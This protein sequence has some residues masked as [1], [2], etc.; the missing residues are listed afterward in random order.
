[1]EE[2]EQTGLQTDESASE[3]SPDATSPIGRLSRTQVV[4]ILGAAMMSL[5]LAA[6]DQTIVATALPRIVADVGGIDQISWVVTSYLVMSTTLVPI[7]GRVSDIY[8]RK[9]LFIAGIL[10]FLA[11]SVLS[12]ISQNMVQL[13]LSR[14][15]QGGGAGF[16]MSNAFTVVGDVF[17][18]AERGKWTGLIGAVFGLASVVGPVAGGALTDNLSWR[19]VFYVNIPISLLALV[20]IIVSMP[21]FG[22]KSLKESVDYPGAAA[23][24][25][26]LIPLFLAISLGSQTYSWAS[27]QVVLLFVFSGIM[28]AVWLFIEHRTPSPILPLSMFRNRIFTVIAITTFLTGVGMFG[29]ILFIPLFVQGVIGSSATNSGLVML[30]MMLAIVVGSI[31]GGQLLSRIGHYQILSLAGIGI[32]TSGMVLLCLMDA[33]TSNREVTLN[34]VLMGFGLGI[35]FPVFTIVVQNAFHHSFMGVVTASVQFFRSTGGALG[36]A[37]MGA[38]LTTRLSRNLDTGLPQDAVNALGPDKV[39]HLRDPNA[40]VDPASRLFLEEQF[41]GMGDRGVELMES[42]LDA[43][44]VA[45]A[46][47]LTDIFLVATIVVAVSILVLVFLKEIPLRKSYG[48]APGSQC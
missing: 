12:G 18:P 17:P 35:G 42:L 21:P 36:V 5:F 25:L 47:A 41:A 39:G 7:V 26:T 8:G 2:A 1:M 11:G 31:V 40:L 37:V 33:D 15:V 48:A 23:L 10:I 3:A 28:F 46:N 43:M 9:P 19:W 27:T 4:L 6:L 16:L 45:L 30:P 13:I 38:I 20:A 34:M 24:V 22:G 29:S 44:K 14:G 32:M